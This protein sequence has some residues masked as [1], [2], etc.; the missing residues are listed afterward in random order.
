MFNNRLIIQLKNLL[1]EGS[2]SLIFEVESS[3]EKTHKSFNVLI[4]NVDYDMSK[5]V[6]KVSN[7]NNLTELEILKKARLENIQF[8]CRLEGHSEMML[9]NSCL[10]LARANRDLKSIERPISEQTDIIINN[11]FDNVLDFLSRLN[12]IYC[13]WKPSNIL[14]F[15]ENTFKLTD[16]GS[17][18]QSNLKVAHPNN[19]NPIYCSPYLMN[20]YEGTC[21]I[22]K[23]RD[24]QIGVAYVYLWLKNHILPWS[25]FDP[26]KENNNFS[27]VTRLIFSSKVDPNIHKFNFDLIKLP[28]KYT[29]VLTNIYEDFKL[30]DS[31]DI[32][33]V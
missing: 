8:I 12:I 30:N 7:K 23:F 29:Q 6:A 27:R 4:N 25:F 22:P 16:F 2:N 31:N 20:L 9:N 10:L 3:R 33:L 21:I 5:L 19:I 24:D 13:D 28:L 11:F 32:S 18:L 1:A 15:G 26:I 14:E 17:C